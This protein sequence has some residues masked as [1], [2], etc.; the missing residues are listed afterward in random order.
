VDADIGRPDAPDVARG[1]VH[2][3]TKARLENARR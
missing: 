2:G 3:A 1:G